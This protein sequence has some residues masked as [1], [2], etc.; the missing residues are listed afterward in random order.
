MPEPIIDRQVNDTRP[1]QND[2]NWYRVTLVL[3]VYDR[4]R[5]A[6][7]RE[8]MAGVGGA[9]V[10]HSLTSASAVVDYLRRTYDLRV[11]TAR[12]EKAHT[13]LRATRA[14]DG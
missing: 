11:K 1:V 2:E 6:K 4:H 13:V 5:T 8:D 3:D 7:D 9:C 14:V 12:V 10:A